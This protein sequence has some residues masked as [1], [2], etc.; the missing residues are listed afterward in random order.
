MWSSGSL[1]R[2]TGTG[3]GS[4]Q[5]LWVRSAI[6]GLPR[7]G[8]TCSPPARTFTERRALTA[9]PPIW[10]RAAASPPL[11][12]QPPG[13]RRPQPAHGWEP[14][15][16]RALFPGKCFPSCA[17]P[18]R[19][20]PLLGDKSERAGRTRLPR[21][22]QSQSGVRGA[23]SPLPSGAPGRGRVLEAH[24]SQSVF[25]SSSPASHSGGS[26]R[27]GGAAAL[28]ARCLKNGIFI[29]IWASSS[30]KKQRIKL[31]DS[32]AASAGRQCGARGRAG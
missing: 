17:A 14:R 26:R 3:V 18:R 1:C 15:G 32:E 5:R 16:T 8:P 19:A 2:E 21:L 25:P 27:P 22:S 10:G 12:P 20:P 28:N 6:A 9:A 7:P 4:Q 13:G 30:K 23:G 29:R 11:P 24:R 31:L